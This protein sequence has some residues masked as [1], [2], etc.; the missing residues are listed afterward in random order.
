MVGA[1]LEGTS[2]VVMRLRVKLKMSSYARSAGKQQGAERAG[3]W[4]SD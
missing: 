1:V 4:V 2:E 3:G